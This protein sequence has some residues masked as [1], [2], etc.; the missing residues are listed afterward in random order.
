MPTTPTRKLHELFPRCDFGDDP[1][2]DQSKG[3]IRSEARASQLR[4]ESGKGGETT[5]QKRRREMYER[6]TGAV[7]RGDAA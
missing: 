6:T 1:K 2:S 3:I 5:D 7:L 4:A